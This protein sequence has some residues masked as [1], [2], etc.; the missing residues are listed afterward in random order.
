VLRELADPPT[1]NIAPSLARR[2]SGAARLRTTGAAAHD[3]IDPRTMVLVARC[4]SAQ[5]AD[6]AAD[7]FVERHGYEPDIVPVEEASTAPN[8]APYSF[9][10]NPQI[11][12]IAGSDEPVFILRA[13]DKLAAELVRDWAERAERAGSPH[14]KVI[15][16]LA[17]ADAMDAWPVKKVPD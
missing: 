9:R 15:D 14:A 3:V 8:L 10:R 1:Q 12:K 5:D 17:C 7:A 11:V 16:A 2:A 13:Q 4:D 6:R